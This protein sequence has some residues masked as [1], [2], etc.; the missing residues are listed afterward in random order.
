LIQKEIVDRIAQ[1][2]ITG[3]LHDNSHVLID[4]DDTGDYTCRV[5]ANLELEGSIDDLVGSL[6]ELDDNN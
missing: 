5:E 4:I 3:E 6:Y 2:V 1:K